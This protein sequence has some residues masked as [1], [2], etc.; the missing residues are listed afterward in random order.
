MLIEVEGGESIVAFKL[1]EEHF[2][3]TLPE[4]NKPAIIKGG[5]EA[6]REGVHIIYKIIGTEPVFTADAK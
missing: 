4:W 6:F 2:V 3:V 5:S 1:G